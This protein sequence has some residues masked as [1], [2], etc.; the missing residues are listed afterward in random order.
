MRPFH[1][2]QASFLLSLTIHSISAQLD[3]GTQLAYPTEFDITPVLASTDGFISKEDYASNT[4][5]KEC[6][7]PDLQRRMRARAYD[8]DDPPSALCPYEPGAAAPLQYNLKQP[9]G[10]DRLQLDGTKNDPNNPD[11]NPHPDNEKRK[12]WERLLIPLQDL[13]RP[14][15]EESNDNQ[16]AP[17]MSSAICPDPNKQVAVC[18]AES[19]YLPG[20]GELVIEYCRF[21]AFLFSFL[22]PLYLLQSIS[23][24]FFFFLFRICLQ[25][26]IQLAFFKKKP[27]SDLTIG[28]GAL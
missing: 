28:T 18:S 7:S 16:R 15:R 6:H 22:Y 21:R 5:N 27:C 13:V 25:A 2:S 26:H 14:G 20:P 4:D 12:W 17:Y 23:P 3:L 10:V 24:F 9:P 19:P 11:P 1:P 8:Q